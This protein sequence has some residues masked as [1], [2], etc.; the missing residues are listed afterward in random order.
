MLVFMSDLHFTDGTGGQHNPPAKVFK[1]VFSNLGR[2]AARAKAKEIKIVL[3]GDIFDLLRTQKWLDVPAAERPWGTD[4]TAVPGR[5]E[6]ILDA[7]VTTNAEALAVFNSDLEEE[8]AFPMRPEFTYVI[9][10]HDRL[11]AVYPQLRDAACGALGATTPSDSLHRFVDEHYA[12]VARH[13]HEYDIY[14]YE[15]DD[16]YSDEQHLNMPIGDPITTELASR[17]PRLVL[18]DPVVREHLTDEEMDILGRNLKEIDNVRPLAATLRWL[19]YR[20]RPGDWL[21]DVID[22]AVGKGVRE[23][24][25][26]SAVKAWYERHDR[27]FDPVDEADLLQAGLAVAGNLDVAAIDVGLQLAGKLLTLRDAVAARDEMATAAVRELEEVGSDDIRYVM[28][29]HTHEAGVVPLS[30]AESLL[31]GT[32]TVDREPDRFYINTGAYR[33]RNQEVVEGDGFASWKQLSYTIVYSKEE[34]SVDGP[35]RDYPT[36]DTWTGNRYSPGD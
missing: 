26:I 10:N 11:L 32:A 33:A 29:G 27:W 14:N 2:I 17:L 31:A 22:N 3:L 9:G 1:L 36:F 5:A 30:A 25:A 34:G 8:F 18:E 6:A 19:R 23:F 35:H 21:S 24:N 15:G 16:P 7:I 12:V 28:Y 4:A 13:G 20:V